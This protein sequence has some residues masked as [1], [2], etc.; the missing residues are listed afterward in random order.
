[1][2]TARVDAMREAWLYPP[3][4]DDDEPSISSHIGDVP[5]EVFFFAERSGS[6]IVTRIEDDQGRDIPV[7]DLAFHVVCRLRAE[8]EREAA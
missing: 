3:D 2:S 1:M 4:H 6:A 8:C 7:R 5:V